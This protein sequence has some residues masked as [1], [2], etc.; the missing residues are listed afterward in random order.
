MLKNSYKTLEY[1]KLKTLLSKYAVSDLG[2]EQIDNLTPINELHEI[3]RLL[4]LCS[5]AKELY[6]RLNGFPLDG[7]K[8]IRNILWRSSKPGAVLDPTQLLDLSKF[9]SVARN[10][11]RLVSANKE[12]ICYGVWQ[13]VRDLSTFPSLAEVINSCVGDE[14]E[15]L[16]TAS[17]ELRKIRRQKESVRENIRSKLESI[18]RSAEYS[19]SIQDSVITFRNDRFVIPIKRDYKGLISGIVQGESNSGATIFMEP[20][21]VVSLNNSLHRLASEEKQELRRILLSLSDAVREYLDEFNEAVEILAELDF[22]GAKARLSIDFR[23]AEPILNS[24]GY[25]KLID[26]RHPLLERTLKERK[27]QRGL[28]HSTSEESLLPD[29][30]VPIDF[31]I[32][33]NDQD[34]RSTFDRDDPPFNTLVI[35]GPNT[36]GKTIVLKTVGLLTLMAQS[37]LHIPAIDGSELAVFDQIFADIGDEQSIEQNLSTFSSHI[38]KIIEI[39]DNASLNSLVLLDEIGAGTDPT[40]G[41]AI[42][43]AVVD[44]L[45]SIGTKTAVTTHHSVLKTYAHS[46]DGMENASVDFDWHTLRPTF[47]L[48]IGVPGS[49]NALKIAEQIG[50]A[51]HIIQV[52]KEYIGDRAIAVEDLIVSMEEERRELENER[53]IVQEK[54]RSA[55]Q[56]QTEHENLVR[57]FKEQKQELDLRA[58]REARAIVTNARKTIENTVEQLRKEQASKKQI[59]KSHRTVDELKEELESKKRKSVLKEFAGKIKIGDKIRIKSLERF[60]EV[61]ENPDITKGEVVAQVGNMKITVSLPDV[62]LT[63]PEFNRPKISPSIIEIQHLKKSSIKN[64]IHIRGMRVFEAMKKVD[65]YID[66]AFLAELSRVRIIHGKGTGTLKKAVHDF[67]DGHPHI[68]DY[69]LAPLS[70]GGYGVTIVKFE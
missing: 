42:G 20:K 58:E 39:V 66:D 41:S 62:E 32:G 33:G 18:M 46:R 53:Q 11:K 14:G 8:D 19:R 55:S 15:I 10:A 27:Y 52:A 48:K 3:E 17:Q 54:I 45:H 64:E 61:V 26:A 37:G 29:K 25:I 5:E 12:E 16:D 2:R 60:G 4:S 65:K 34:D 1:D 56:A 22:L 13:I 68:F 50:L 31:R 24:G 67:L 23:G 40:E 63:D 28:D 49:S 36:G 44:Y 43:M 9:V 51:E 7:L 47:K 59:K 57:E 35:T 38:K 30:I 21:S 6:Q 70:E 69:Q